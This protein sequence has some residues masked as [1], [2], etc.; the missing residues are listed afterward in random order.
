MVCIKVFREWRK[1]CSPSV[2]LIHQRCGSCQRRLQSPPLA[3]RGGWR[4]RKNFTGEIASPLAHMQTGIAVHFIKRTEWNSTPAG[5]IPHSN[6]DDELMKERA[7]GP[8]AKLSGNMSWAD[9][10]VH[11]FVF[12]GAWGISRAGGPRPGGSPL[13]RRKLRAHA[14][15]SSSHAT[16]RDLLRDFSVSRGTTPV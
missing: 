14:V 15:L 10:W 3:S 1:S 4:I 7:R 2:P 12:L 5:G 8:D 13:S 16:L 6:F 11:R 9:A